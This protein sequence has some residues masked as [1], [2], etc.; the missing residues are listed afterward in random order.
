MWTWCSRVGLKPRSALPVFPTGSAPSFILRPADSTSINLRN[1]IAP[2]K[3]ALQALASNWK[4]VH[5]FVRARE[6]DIVRP[7]VW[8]CVKDCRV[9]VLYNYRE[10]LQEDVK[11]SSD[12]GSHVQLYRND[13]RQTKL[14]IEVD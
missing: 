4:Q 9:R 7:N 3:I 1:A 11:S 8:T 6:I 5:S 2:S 10:R 12:A 14:K 13:H